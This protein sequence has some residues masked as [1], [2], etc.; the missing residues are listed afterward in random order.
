MASTEVPAADFKD[1]FLNLRAAFTPFELPTVEQVIQAIT[2]AFARDERLT[3]LPNRG[4]G[5]GLYRVVLSRPVADPTSHVAWFP[6]S[7][8]AGISVA[9][10]ENRPASREA[11]SDRRP[12]TLVTFVQAT[13]GALA[14][15]KNEAFD[16]AMGAFGEVVKPTQPQ[17]IRGQKVM[18][19]NR[20]C[21]VDRGDKTI[22]GTIKVL[23]INTQKMV[24]V[25]LQY[26]GQQS[27]CRRCDAYH[28]GLCE[29][30]KKFYAARDARKVVQI[31]MK[32][33]SDSTLRLAE[34]VGLRGDVLCIS[35][36]GVGH[37]ANAVRD[38]PAMPEMGVVAVIKGGN[39][40]IGAKYECGND[41]VF[42][43]DKS[44]EK[45]KGIFGVT[46]DKSF[47]ILYPQDDA[48][49]HAQP[50]DSA[51]Q[52]RYLERKLCS[53][54]SP[55]VAVVPIPV[56]EVDTDGRGHPTMKGTMTILKGLDERLPEDLFFSA[57][58]ATSR[59][60][61][62]GVQGMYRFGCRTC[63]A[64]GERYPAPLE[65]CSSCRTEMAT[66]D[67]ASKWAIFV[68]S[69]AVT[70]PGGPPSPSGVE[71]LPGRGYPEFSHGLLCVATAK[72]DLDISVDV[73][74]AL[75]RVVTAA[76][77][78]LAENNSDGGA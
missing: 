62:V 31:R 54:V 63:A 11:R 12:G 21:V 59:C 8:D 72:R 16:A 41:F 60:P 20:Y 42:T 35:G 2:T 75:K 74:P 7:T 27:W 76:T 5:L 69:L 52:G 23:D 57:E 37:L 53:L 34:T 61:Y 13:L 73:M 14:G 40:Y 55:T 47:T 39:D 43:V 28:I 1:L 50:P 6:G 71:S 17:N 64:K 38:D 70:P 24:P 51:L 15:I 77:T 58:L 56:H 19:G 44:V 36:G 25:H 46:P 18:N 33:V 65:I 29:Y 22:P 49:E 68:T 67:R 10:E 30:L 26:K 3:V 4:S 66:Y 9:F 32:V 45:L 78:P 48:A